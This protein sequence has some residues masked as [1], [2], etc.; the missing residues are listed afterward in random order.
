MNDQNEQQ[1]MNNNNNNDDDVTSTRRQQHQQIRT[2]RTRHNR[3]HRQPKR[4]GRPTTVT[5]IPGPRT[6]SGRPRRRRNNT[7]YQTIET[8]T[9]TQTPTT[10]TRT[11]C[12]QT[13]PT[14]IAT[15][16][17]RP[18][19]RQ[20]QQL[21]PVEQFEGDEIP[22]TYNVTTNTDTI[23]YTDAPLSSCPRLPRETTDIVQVMAAPSVTVWGLIDHLRR[24]T[25]SLTIQRIV[26]HIGYPTLRRIQRRQTALEID[27]GGVPDDPPRQ[28]EDD[29][30]VLQPM[31]YMID[32][33]MDEIRHRFPL[34]SLTVIPAKPGPLDCDSHTA[35][36][37]AGVCAETT[38][39]CG[40][41]ATVRSFNRHPLD[42]VFNVDYDEDDEDA[43]EPLESLST[44]GQRALQGLL[45]DILKT[46]F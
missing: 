35:R 6:A 43:F 45:L 1:M 22:D 2:A 46:P 18:R 15:I 44:T 4:L 16:I 5:R 33:L 25:P 7:V 8:G 19:P 23:V 40:A 27:A 26:L 41:T 34:A 21:V 32:G 36:L 42:Y 9:S 31:Y 29:D 20:Q 24:L 38:M 17:T 11:T 37:W 28:W 10:V 13:V 3:R 30:D 12:T 39:N 14:G